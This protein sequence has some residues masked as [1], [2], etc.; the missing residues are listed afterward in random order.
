MTNCTIV[1]SEL[2][3][4][5]MTRVEERLGQE[6]PYTSYYAPLCALFFLP[7]DRY[8]TS[9]SR[10]LP[11]YGSYQYVQDLIGNLIAVTKFLQNANLSH[12]NL[13]FLKL[14]FL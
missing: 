9:T 5:G 1:S 14:L 13:T 8:N 12:D 7:G 11:N 2:A 3:T 4:S 6:N 10:I